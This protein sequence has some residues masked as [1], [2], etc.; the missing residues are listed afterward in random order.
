MASHY[1]SDLGFA[2]GIQAGYAMFTYY[3]IIQM[4]TLLSDVTFP[5]SQT[6][7]SETYDVAFKTM[8]HWSLT[9]LRMAKIYHAESL[10]VCF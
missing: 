4:H 8:M 9:L 1:N 7:N 6:L 3:F 5:F 2:S 10:I